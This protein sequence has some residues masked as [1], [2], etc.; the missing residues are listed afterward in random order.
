[1]VSCVC[2]LDWLRDAQIAVKRYYRVS[3]RVFLEEVST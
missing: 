3:V 1:M 2:Q